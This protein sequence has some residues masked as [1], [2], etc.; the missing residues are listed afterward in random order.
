[1]PLH[2]VPYNVVP[3]LKLHELA[4]ESIISSTY[5]I[6]ANFPPNHMLTKAS[7][8]YT[9]IYGIPTTN[10]QSRLLAITRAPPSATMPHKP[11]NGVCANTWNND[12]LSEIFISAVPAVSQCNQATRHSSCTFHGVLAEQPPCPQRLCRNCALLYSAPAGKFCFLLRP[13]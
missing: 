8:P 2:V 5:R 7:S 9:F 3:R 4:C 1:M 13:C 10:E 6:N 11:E 12:K